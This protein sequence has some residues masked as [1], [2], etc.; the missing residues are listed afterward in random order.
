MTTVQAALDPRIW[1]PQ[2]QFSA[3]IASP[4]QLKRFNDTGG[5]AVHLDVMR[6]TR[7]DIA[8]SGSQSETL[9]VWETRSSSGFVTKPKFVAGLVTIRFVTR[10]HVVSSRRTGDLLASTAIATLTGFEELHEVH[11]SPAVSAVSAT[12]A[13]A[14]LAAA[15]TALTG[16]DQPGLPALAP[17]AEMTRPGM[18]SLFCTIRLIQG[19]IQGLDRRADLVLPLLEEVMSYQLLST[20]P[21]RAD[22]TPAPPPDVAPRRLRRAIDYIEAHL[23]TALTLAD[24]ATAAGIGVRSLQNTFR[25]ELGRTPV[26]FIIDRRLARAHADLLADTGARRSIAEIARCWGFV[27][28]SDFGQRYR[29]LHGCTPSETRRQAQRGH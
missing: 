28:M 9:S 24:V 27:H 19:R 1:R 10:G 12:I 13:A 4:T 16:S 26:Q 29:R 8:I 17:I 18:G 3:S 25:T 5:I 23:A 20:W 11:A 15:N 14:T 6:E 7:P 21:K 22:G 2:A